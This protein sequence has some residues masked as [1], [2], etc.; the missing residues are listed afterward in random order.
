VPDYRAYPL[1][2]KARIAA[3]RIDFVAQTDAEALDQAKRLARGHKVEVWQGARRI[4]SVRGS[5]DV[6]QH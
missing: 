5:Q 1:L 6:P 4:G 3:L 2:G